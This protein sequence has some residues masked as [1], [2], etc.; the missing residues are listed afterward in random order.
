METATISKAEQKRIKDATS[1]VRFKLS[2]KMIDFKELYL[3]ACVNYEIRQVEN[4]LKSCQESTEEF[5][6]GTKRT[7]LIEMIEK[8]LERKNILT[9]R[10]INEANDSYEAKVDKIVQKLIKFG[11]SSRHLRVERTETEASHEFSFL[12]SNQ[13]IEVHARVIYACGMIN[14]PHF[15]FITT[16]RNK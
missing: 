5:F 6:R 16:K 14:V 13:E 3:D 7:A 9:L 2:K 10:F 8:Q 1:A 11:F 12:I 15:R 4:R